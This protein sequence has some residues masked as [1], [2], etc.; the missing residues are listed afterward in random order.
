ML[1]D[2][3]HLTFTMNVLPVVMVHA[4]FTSIGCA[5]SISRFAKVFHILP[6][7]DIWQ[8]S[9]FKVVLIVEAQCNDV[10]TNTR[11]G[12]LCVDHAV[13]NGDSLMVEGIQQTRT[14]IDVRIPLTLL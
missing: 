13:E 2:D 3:A 9:I 7:G 11:I 8:E 14:A 6:N 1:G 12:S 10:R 5:D 4:L